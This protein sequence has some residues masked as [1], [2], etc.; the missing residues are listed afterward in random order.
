LQSLGRPGGRPKDPELKKLLSE[1]VCVRVVQMWG[2]DL[3]RF[4]IDRV[5]TWAVFFL[6][7]D[8][9]IYGRYG[10]RSSMG[11]GSD[12][13]ISLAGFK[14]SMTAALDEH[15]RFGKDPEATR[16]EV[17]GK[18]SVHKP[19]WARPEKIP[20]L[21]RNEFNAK[22]FREFSDKP[23]LRAHGVGCIHGHMVQSAEIMSLRELGQPVP[24]R[25]V[26]PYPMPWAVGLHMEPET[27]STIK[28]VVGNTV[29][30]EAGLRAGD[31]I[32]KLDG[33]SILSTADIQWILHYAKDNAALKVHY[34]RGSEALES[35]LK[36]SPDWRQKLGDWRFTN[37]GICMQLAGFNGRPGKGGGKSLAI[38][39]GL[40]HRKR[41]AGIDLKRNDVIVAL[42]GKSESMNLGQLTRF[43]LDKKPGSELS[44]TR[45][46]AGEETTTLRW[47]LHK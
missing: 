46:R 9:T 11:Q 37:L 19:R 39:V 23:G 17:A 47:K 2:I 18:Q 35:T 29:A 44:V 28:R 24:D 5:M 20:T 16:K 40:I 30:E 34:T 12:S 21:A 7:A 41:L 13:E 22:P 43:L 27:R 26:W 6:N 36:L 42:D 32:E 33:Q 3:E 8:G 31:T 14:Q 38:R 10:T 15:A 4:Q 1:F 25:K 45:K